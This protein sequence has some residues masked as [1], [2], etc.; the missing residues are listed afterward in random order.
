[1]RAAREAGIS[2]REAG[3][4]AEMARQ[5][6][7]AAELSFRKAKEAVQMLERLASSL[8]KDSARR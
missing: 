4:S 5:A 6:A 3:I 2:A 8:V 1:M 7:V